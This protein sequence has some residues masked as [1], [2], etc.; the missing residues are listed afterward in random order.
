MSNWGGTEA[1][2]LGILCREEYGFICHLC[3]KVI[4]EEEFSTDHVVPRSKGGTNSIENLRPAHRA[5]NSARQDRSIEDYRATITDE[6]SWFT[7][8]DV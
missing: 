5:C 6:I 2:N 1:K 3:H 7:S 4:T 8:L